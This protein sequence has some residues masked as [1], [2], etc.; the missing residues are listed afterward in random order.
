[1]LVGG[2]KRSCGVKDGWAALELKSVLDHEVAVI[3]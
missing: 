1:L 3:R 2:G